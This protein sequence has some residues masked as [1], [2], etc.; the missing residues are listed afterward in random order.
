MKRNPRMIIGIAAAL[1]VIC[2]IWAWLRMHAKN[3][4]AAESAESLAIPTVAVAKVTR[5][6]LSRQA[7]F[8]AE[9]RPYVEVELHA[10]VSGYVDKMNVDFGDK[11]KAGELLATIEVPE[12]QDEL[13]NAIAAEE[14][15][16]ADFTNADL[17][18]TRLVS[19][20]NEHPNLVAQQDLDTASANEQMAAAAIAA[21]RADVGKFQTMIDYTRITAP[22]DGVV[23]RRY[24]DPGSLIQAGTSSDT[25]ALPLVRV[26][27]NYLLRLDF[28]VDL[29]FVQDIHVG[30]PVSVQ[31]ESLGGKTFTGTV[32][33]FTRDVDDNTRKMITEIQVPNPNLE[34]DP[35]MYATVSLDVE[36]HTNTL[37][38]PTEAVINGA[39]PSVYV[40]NSNG[41]IEQRPIQPGLET[42]DEYEVLS[43][44]QEGDLVVVGNHS[45]I[46]TGQKVQPK[47]VALSMKGQ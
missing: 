47:V 33:R 34:I 45:E 28:P 42:A 16:R 38:I 31:V 22:F 44:L 2:L 24:A 11:V 29:D 13:T 6:D 12:L 3:S 4:V 17:I 32:S 8:P 10:K 18:Y 19:V 5:E 46:Q 1:V 40:V 26:S 30:D 15:A 35:G 20:N 41:E 14:K 37:A 21:A 39:T 7:T 25:Q 9:F 43:G 23:T 27:D 36:N